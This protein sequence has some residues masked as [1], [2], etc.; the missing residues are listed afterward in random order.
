MRAKKYIKVTFYE[1]V[2]NTFFSKLQNIKLLE[3]I[4]KNRRFVLPFL[5]VFLLLPV[6]LIYGIISLCNVTQGDSE[7]KL[8]SMPVASV[9]NNKGVISIPSGV[10]KADP[11]VPYG[12][13]VNDKAGLNIPEYD[14][15]PP[16][17]EANIDSDAARVMDTI[18]SGILY[19]AHSPSA[20]LNI[21]GTD[22]LVK[23]GD[24]VNNYKVLAINKNSVT[25][26][27]GQ[28]VYTAGIGEILTEGTINRNEISNLNK[29]FGGA[30]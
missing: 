29:K 16:P 6:S 3:H 8:V 4:R 25:V 1:N 24:V 30:R 19:D 5:F 23:K 22:Y 2:I 26:K 13:N 18:V 15:T 7:I 9:T 28:N 17:E 12:L 27:L 20:I 10:Q 21:E 11:F 14:L